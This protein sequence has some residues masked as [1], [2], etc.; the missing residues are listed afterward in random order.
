MADVPK[1]L[2]N[3]Q[4]PENIPITNPPPPLPTVDSPPQENVRRGRQRRKF[5]LQ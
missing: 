4:A 1:S 5:I 3:P 2:L